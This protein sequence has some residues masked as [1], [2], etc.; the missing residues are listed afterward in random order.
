MREACWFSARLRVKHRE[1]AAEKILA[2]K[3][4]RLQTQVKTLAAPRHRLCVT[5]GDTDINLGANS[6]L[7]Q[8]KRLNASA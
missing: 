8:R 4:T 6:K 5:P 1:G 7:L 2:A 3:V